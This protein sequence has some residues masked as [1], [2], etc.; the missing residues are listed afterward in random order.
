VVDPRRAL[1]DPFGLSGDGFKA[2]YGPYPGNRIMFGL[3]AFFAAPSTSNAS[4]EID[5]D[6]LEGGTTL[7]HQAL[8]AWS[9][10]SRGV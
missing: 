7:T 10:L 3:S 6:S 5:R 8:Q 4:R 2:D 9:P 1:P